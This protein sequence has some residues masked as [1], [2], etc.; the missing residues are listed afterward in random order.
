MLL[1]VDCNGNASFLTNDEEQCSDFSSLYF[2]QFPS[3]QF[4][5]C[6][7]SDIAHV[8]SYICDAEHSVDELEFIYQHE[9]QCGDSIVGF[10][11]SSCDV[12]YYSFNISADIEN[13]VSLFLDTCG[14]SFDS[15]IGLYDDSWS[16]IDECNDDATGAHC[17]Y[18]DAA[19]MYDKNSILNV[20]FAYD[21][22]YIVSI[23]GN[24]V[25]DYGEYTISVQ[26]E[27]APTKSPTVKPTFDPTLHP[28]ANPSND[29]TQ[30]PSLEPTLLPT[31]NPSMEP[32]INP[33]SDPT[34]IP[35]AY[36]SSN[37][38]IF[39]S[40]EPTAEPS[41]ILSRMPTTN[42]TNEQTEEPS[43][44]TNILAN[45]TDVMS[46][47]GK[48]PVNYIAVNSNLV[49]QD[50]D[51]SASKVA[52]IIFVSSVGF[53]FICCAASKLWT[54]GKKRIAAI[55]MNQLKYSIGSVSDTKEGAL[56]SNSTK[57]C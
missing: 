10:T 42:T 49:N 14:T 7:P 19:P 3:V 9:L 5:S 46:I 52:V 24:G 56:R 20:P 30:F 22:S 34:I 39:P 12:H 47:D 45:A 55:R 1:F 4:M 6:N 26:C 53:I 36:P 8:S 37:P 28:T 40:I 15:M 17:G 2:D 11:N 57:G 25:L 23:E 38:T 18:C 13:Y 21:G 48:N 33:S 43:I 50:S 32:T 27:S 54:V 16:L 41:N 31:L 51:I 44:T 35:S 29:P